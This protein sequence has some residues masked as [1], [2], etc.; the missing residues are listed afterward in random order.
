MRSLPRPLLVDQPRLC[1]LVLQEEEALTPL[2]MPLQSHCYESKP[3]LYTIKPGEAV[4][5]IGSH[6]GELTSCLNYV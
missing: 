1:S 2:K 6:R 4:L 3:G 5:F